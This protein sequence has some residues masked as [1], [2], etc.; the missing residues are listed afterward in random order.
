MDEKRDG[1]VL[2]PNNR[3]TTDKH[4][5]FTGKMHIG[6]RDFDLAAWKRKDK[7]GNPY[8]SMMVNPPY[9]RPQPE[10]QP[11]GVD[12]KHDDRKPAWDDE[13]PF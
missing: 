7:N 8:L 1:G 12:A 9:K 13:I 2:F 4:P 5:D 11:S 3:K 6:E 10:E